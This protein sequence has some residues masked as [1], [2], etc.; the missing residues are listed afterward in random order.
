MALMPTPTFATTT[1]EDLKSRILG[2]VIVPG[3]A[4]YDDARKAWNLNVNQ[5]PA[6][7]VI[8]QS[9]ADV[10]EAVRYA[11]IEDLGV[12]VQATGHGISRPADDAVLIIMSEMTTVRI[13]VED[14]TAWIEGGTK[15]G[16]VLQAAQAAGLAPLL[17]SSPIVGAVGYTLGG[18]MGWLARKYG[19]SVDSVNYFEVITA[20]GRLVHASAYENSDLFWGLR[21]GGGSFGV[22]TGMEVQLYPV[23]TVFGGTMLYPA[24]V[25]KEVFT[26]YREWIANAPDELT[27]SISLMNFP[28][29]PQV[30]EFL[31]GQSFV[32]VR[33][34]YC[35]AVADGEA[36]IQPWLDW[37]QPVANQWRAMPFSEVETVSNDPKDPSIGWSTSVWLRELSDEAID[38]LIQRVLPHQGPPALVFAEIRYAGGAISKVNA[39]ANAYGNRDANLV[40]QMIGMAPTPE[41]HR[42]LVEY[43]NLIKRELTPVLTGGIYINF[44]E[45]EEKWNKTKDAFLPETY[46]RLTA[47]KAKYDPENRFRYSFNIPPVKG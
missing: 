37:M 1:L 30:P 31:R 14:Q 15:W 4:D 16:K 13:N 46:Q 3:D 40:L 41:M 44:L 38:T 2:E 10:A 23:T 5:H 47:I 9:A 28:P 33:G 12:A 36:L 19:M 20:D 42:N 26:R 29:I 11:N 18:G 7:I 22:I 21:G 27:S 32:M 43:T 35:G 25:A 6:V 24:S 17:G 8:A 34:L 45:G 39:E